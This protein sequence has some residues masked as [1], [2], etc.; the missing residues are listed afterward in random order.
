MAEQ[1]CP[2]C[3]TTSYR[4]PNLKLL[5]N[6]CGHK[7]CQTCVDV[8]FTRPS[9]ACPE[10]STPLRRSDFRIQQFENALVEKE[11]DIRKRIIKIFNKREEDFGAFDNPLRAY[12]DYLE[13]IEVIIFNLANKIDVEATKKKVEKYKKEN[14]TVIRKINSKISQEDERLK[15][16]FEAEQKEADERRMKFVLDEVNEKKAKNKEKDALIDD[17]IHA[18]ASANEVLAR[19]QM[20]KLQLKKEEEKKSMFF[21]GKSKSQNTVLSKALIKEAPLY[22]YEPLIMEQI[23]PEVPSNEVIIQQG[24]VKN[25]RQATASEKAAGYTESLACQ[26]ALNEAFNGL[27]M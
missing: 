4:N 2:R 19:H 21:Q 23:G 13:E 24:F 17:L 22:R 12:N 26:R 1:A 9:A 3:K 11:V 14:E 6:V 16:Q 25:I 8:L 18:N 27:F 5:V 20:T 7:L 15:L 10:C